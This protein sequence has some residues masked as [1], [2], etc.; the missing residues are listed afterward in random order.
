MS[1]TEALPPIELTAGEIA[2][3]AGGRVVVGDPARR[4]ASL[5]IDSR[6]VPA[7][8]LFV[9]LPGA[10]VD[11]HE[12]VAQAVA[13]GAAGVLVSRAGSWPGA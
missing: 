10:R 1:A 13:A 4:F 8:S 7:G 6:R 3:A 2:S 12:Y 11:G 5:A 9:A